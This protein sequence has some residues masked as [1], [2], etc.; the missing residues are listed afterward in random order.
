MIPL[1]NIDYQLEIV[2]SLMNISL[3]QKYFNP[4]DKFLEVTYSF[5]IAPN[6]SIYKFY[7]EF[8]DVRID[9]V[10]K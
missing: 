9:G 4:S 3:S 6:S 5:P 2:N 7:A 1:K 8:K 10:V